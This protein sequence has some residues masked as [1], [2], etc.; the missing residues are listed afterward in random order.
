MVRA[1]HSWRGS[2]AARFYALAA[3]AIVAV[4][5]L[6]ASSIY[7]AA[8]TETAATHLYGDAYVGVL[9]AT[10]LE[11][12]LE[13]HR[14]IVESMPADVD[15]TRLKSSRAQL[16]TIRT[17]L[18]DLIGGFYSGSSVDTAERRI[19]DSFPLLFQTGDRVAFY[20]YNFAQDKAYEFAEEYSAQ[21][22]N[23]QRLV[24][25]FREQRLKAAEASVSRLLA[26]AKS[27]TAWVI[28]CT[29]VALIL[30]GPIGLM[31]AHKVLAR[32]GLI[33]EAMAKLARNDT[34]LA[35]PSRDDTDEIGQMARA[36]EIFKDNAIKLG[37]REA[38]LAQVNRQLDVA[39]NNMTHGLC[40]FDAKQNL[41]V[42]NETY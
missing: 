27:L 7:F 14:R 40:M 38:E 3:L 10:R 29:I 32:L 1:L 9:N 17:R 35:V 33:T 22:D 4:G 24:Q 12:L 30:I 5:G 18:I 15:R 42:C 13:Q 23:T 19:A 39:L 37:A 36:V 16:D 6:A 25:S 8:T 20:A 31:I 21:A 26:A 28:L 41:T 34:T 11:L 2:V